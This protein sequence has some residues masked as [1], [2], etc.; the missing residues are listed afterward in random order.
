MIEV[1]KSKYGEEN[2]EE[3]LFGILIFNKNIKYTLIHVNE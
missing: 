2:I 3:E 1:E